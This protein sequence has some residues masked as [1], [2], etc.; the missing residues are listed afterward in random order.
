MLHSL[1][2][3]S[4][5]SFFHFILLLFSSFI[6]STFYF[7]LNCNE[8][9]SHQPQ[10]AVVFV[11][12]CSTATFKEKSSF[13]QLPE[14]SVLKRVVTAAARPAVQITKRMEVRLS[15]RTSAQEV[16]QF[17]KWAILALQKLGTEAVLQLLKASLTV[18]TYAM[19]DGLIRELS[20]PLL[21]KERSWHSAKHCSGLVVGAKQ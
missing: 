7:K 3:H 4:D 16:S 13:L 14:K 21:R 6:S 2:Y 20:S 5:H 1:F 15:G 18:H 19:K 9:S 10:H 12:F 17:L 11:V 8:L